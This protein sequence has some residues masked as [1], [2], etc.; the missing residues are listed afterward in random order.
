MISGFFANFSFKKSNADLGSRSYSQNK[1]PRA[2][3]F[4]LLATILGDKFI[5]SAEILTSLLIS[6]CI[7]LYCFNVLFSKG[8]SS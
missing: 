1:I 4:V 8:F 3:I 5:P 6:T 2:N 7:S